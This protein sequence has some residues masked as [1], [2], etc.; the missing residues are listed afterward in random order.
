MTNKQTSCGHFKTLVLT[1][2]IGL[3]VSGI[4][5]PA[6]ALAGSGGGGGTSTGHVDSIKV[7]KNYYAAANG[8][9]LINVSSSDPTAHLYVY[10][11][12]G[13]LLGEV[14]NGGG[15]RYGGSVFWVGADPGYTV[16]RS[17]SG[18]S[19]SVPTAPFQL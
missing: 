2:I 14:Q 7:S 11:P 3:C 18:G 10:L 13:R 4:T 16:F 9:M 17:S 15:G 6:S 19:I 8:T 5:A 12:S 1:I